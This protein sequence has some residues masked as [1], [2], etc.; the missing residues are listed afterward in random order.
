VPAIVQ[1]VQGLLDD[2]GAAAGQSLQRLTQ[3]LTRP[4][5][6]AARGGSPP[7]PRGG[8]LSVVQQQQQHSQQQ[9]QQ[10]TRGS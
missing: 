6:A 4:A 7:Q 5:A 1:R 2:A 3:R 10:Q 8:E 9:H